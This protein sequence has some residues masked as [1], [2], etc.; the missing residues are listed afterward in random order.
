MF[1]YAV[2]RAS[3][4]S[5]IKNKV[6]KRGVRAEASDGGSISKMGGGEAKPM[7][8]FFSPTI[9]AGSGVARNLKKGGGA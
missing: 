2:Q 5:W 1:S 7:T 6:Y 3:T 4:R 8:R 9:R